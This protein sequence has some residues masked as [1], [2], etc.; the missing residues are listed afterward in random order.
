M[1]NQK[2]NRLPDTI[3]GYASD[4]EFFHMTYGEFRNYCGGLLSIALF[5]N[6]FQSEVTNVISMSTA[7]GIRQQM[8]DDES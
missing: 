2:K 6:R 5:D 7:R 8:L 4:A 1:K 3:G